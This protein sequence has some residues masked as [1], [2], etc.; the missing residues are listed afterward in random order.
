VAAL[1]EAVVLLR[2]MLRALPALSESLAWAATP[3]LK[4]IRGNL[5][6]PELGELLGEVEGA[7]E[8]EAQ[9]GGLGWLVGVGVGV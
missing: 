3:L 1:V 5:V 7:L 8:E 6:R 9:V 2:C 4:A